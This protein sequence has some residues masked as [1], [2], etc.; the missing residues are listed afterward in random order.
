MESMEKRTKPSRDRQEAL[1]RTQN[2]RP[3]VL[4]LPSGRGS[5]TPLKGSTF[6]SHTLPRLGRYNPD[7]TI[8][9]SKNA[10]TIS[11]TIAYVQSR[12]SAKPAAHV[13][14]RTTGVAIRIKRPS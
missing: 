4:S 3:F 5:V 11:D 12:S 6:I 7:P 10:N 1:P 2:Y 9:A 13:I 8:L 14:T